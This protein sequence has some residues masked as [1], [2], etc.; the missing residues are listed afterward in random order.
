MLKPLYGLDRRGVLRADKVGVAGAF[1]PKRI[2]LLTW[3]DNQSGFPG[4]KHVVATLNNLLSCPQQSHNSSVMLNLH[5]G[6]T[7]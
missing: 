5:T 7:K 2:A 3:P 1:L 4:T 6:A